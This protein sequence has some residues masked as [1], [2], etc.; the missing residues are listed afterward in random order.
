MYTRPFSS[1][2]GRVGSEE[3]ARKVG[4][5]EEVASSGFGNTRRGERFGRVLQLLGQL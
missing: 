4:Q 2:C 5:E 1:A 3:R